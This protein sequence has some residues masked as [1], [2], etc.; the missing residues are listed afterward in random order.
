MKTRIAWVVVLALLLVGCGGA[1]GDGQPLPTVILAADSSGS[2]QTPGAPAGAVGGSVTASGVVAPAQEA[3]LA[4]AV[5]GRID[6]VFVGVGDQVESGQLLARL[7]GGEALQAAVSAAELKVLTAQQTLDDFQ[8]DSSWKLALAQAQSDLAA[9]QDELKDAEYN[10]SV[11]QPGNRASQLTIDAAEAK[12]V[13]AKENLDRAKRAYDH[14]A[15]DPSDDP[16][17]AE[18][19]ANWVNAQNAYNSA[20][21]TVN[22]YKG[23]PTELEQSKLDAAVAVAEA[24]VEEAQQRVADLQDGP[25]PEKLALLKS[26]LSSAQDEAA[27][28]R[29][30]SDELE[31]K[32]PFAGS[33]GKIVA[34]SGE[35]I[36]PGQGVMVLADLAHLEIQTTDLSERDVPSVVVGQ[37][38]SVSIEALNT[39]VDATVREVSPLA[40]TLGGDVVYQTTLALASIP[41]GLKPGMSVDVQFL[42][43]P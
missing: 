33:V 20:L 18:A 8:S 40:D 1:S 39:S 36:I 37:S 42:A 34:H 19:L 30:A 29:A 14:H 5:A 22:W 38:A 12:L 28:A 43:G 15:D 31:L 7:A 11:N 9:A 35:W 17:R 10:R 21:R 26:Q 41:D 13:L 2:V 25:D 27:A 23:H 24:K 3:Q 4:F 16:R 32:A 6:Q